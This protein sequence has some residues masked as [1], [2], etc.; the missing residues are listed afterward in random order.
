MSRCR[1]GIVVIGRNEGERLGR[2]LRSSIGHAST[3]VYVDSGSVDGS[4]RLAR[5][6]GVDVVQLDMSRPFTAARARNAG[7]RRLFKL[8]RDIEFVQFLDGDCELQGEWIGA[9]EK[10]MRRHPR[11]AVVCGRTRER[12]PDRSVFNQLCDWEWDTPVGEAT[13]CGGN[14]MMRISAFRAMRGFRETLIAGE[15]PELCVR[16]RKAG[17]RIHR[18]DAEM[19]LHDAAM[20]RLAQWWRRTVRSG[21]AYAE[22]A[23]LHGAPPMRHWVRETW[24]ALAFGFV[25]PVL[26]LLAAMLV[27]PLALLV[28]AIYPLQVARLALRLGSWRRAFFLVLA[29]FPECWGVITFHARR[30]RG[31]GSVLIEY[32]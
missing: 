30:L 25:V 16:L 13:S 31:A 29:R 17:W 3:V 5:E 15:E 32:K 28:L 14:A 10:F 18:L 12:H 2:C 7:C 21:H 23:W 27:A 8:D 20:T 24:R 4:P 26:V 19:V 22:G 6:L 1:V 11:L 9:A